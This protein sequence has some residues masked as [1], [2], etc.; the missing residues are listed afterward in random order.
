MSY[1]NHYRKSS[2]D[3]FK[4]YLPADVECKTIDSEFMAFAQNLSAT[5]AFIIT[6]KTL[7][8]G[9]EI[10]MIIK[11]PNS[12]DTIKATGDIVRITAE[13]VGVQFTIFFNK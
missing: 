9:Q 11:F 6:Q 7:S 2:R 10:A 3:Y 4:K 13:G 12:G 5:G 8:M 1:L